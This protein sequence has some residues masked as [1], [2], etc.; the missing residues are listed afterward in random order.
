MGWLHLLFL[1]AVFRPPET[2]RPLRG[3]PVAVLVQV[4]QRE[5]RAQPLVVLMQTPVAH[6]CK[7]EVTL[8]NTKW[9]L[10]LGPDSGLGRI[11]ALGFFVY[12]V[13]EPGPAAGH[14]LRLGRGLMNRFRLPLIT[15]VSPM[16]SSHRRAVTPVTYA[17]RHR[18]P[19]WLPPNA[20]RPAC[21][22]RRY[23]PWPRSTIAFLSWSDASPDRA[24][25]SS[26]WST[27]EH[28]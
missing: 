2:L 13:L 22:P 3:Q 26:S 14:I 8:Q 19:P 10:H 17:H 23:A 21:Y 12:I 18:W 16:L 27:R 7:S 24:R 20:P 9:M 15:G 5:G 11:L 4:Q 1:Q 25:R 28:G 6:L